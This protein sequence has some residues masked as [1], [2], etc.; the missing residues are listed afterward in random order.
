[1]KQLIFKFIPECNTDVSYY[2]SIKLIFCLNFNFK[3]HTTI[4]SYIFLYFFYIFKF[5]HKI[6]NSTIE[7]NT[8]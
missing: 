3:P 4:E 7:P 6:I 8:S 5:F 1:M 2:N